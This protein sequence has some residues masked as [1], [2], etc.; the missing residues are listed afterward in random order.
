MKINI[1]LA[2]ISVLFLCT[3]SYCLNVVNQEQLNEIGR[4]YGFYKGQKLVLKAMSSKHSELKKQALYLDIEFDNKFIKSLQNMENSAVDK[5][6]Q[7]DWQKI[8]KNIDEHINKTDL[9][10]LNKENSKKILEIVDLRIKGKS[11]VSMIST[12]ISFHPKYIQNPLYEVLD[13]LVRE[14]KTGGLEKSLGLNIGC[15]VPITWEEMD[16]SAPHIVKKFVGKR[17]DHGIIQFFPLIKEVPA[18]V[19]SAYKFLGQEEILEAISDHEVWEEAIPGSKVIDR[20]LTMIAGEKASWTEIS[21]ASESTFGTVYGHG[22][23]YTMIFHD[24]IVQLYYS[25]SNVS[26][27]TEIGNFN[28]FKRYENIF[29]LLA[30]KIYIYNKFQ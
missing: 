24:K 10:W 14:F 21:I 1:V 26:E 6:G 20:G 5:L 17:V 29:K 23:V 16:A 8:K 3:N 22:I 7:D 13:N 19:K 4:A 12:F 2:L 25:V 11:D 18:E 15:I 30:S 9:S 28:L 27:N